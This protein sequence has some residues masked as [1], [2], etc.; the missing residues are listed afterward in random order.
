MRS[1]S[2]SGTLVRS[3]LAALG[4]L[5]L[6][7]CGGGGGD[8]GAI[9]PPATGTPP[10]TQ[11]PAPDPSYSI[12]ADEAS[13][14]R[15]LSVATFGGTRDEIAALVGRDAADWLADE[16][17]KPASP[18][19]E[20]VL[21][22][23]TFDT[24]Q[25][26]NARA[27]RPHHSDLFWEAMIGADDQLRQRMLFALSQIIVVSEVNLRQ[28]H[29]HATYMDALYENA[30]GNYRDVLYDVTYTPTMSDYLTYRGSRKADANTGRLPDENY[31]REILQLFSIGLVEL[32]P[33]GTPRLVGGESVETFDNDDIVNL[34][35]VFTGM[36]FDL[37]RDPEWLTWTVP[38]VHNANAHSPESKVF[39]GVNI[40]ENTDGATSV[41][42][43]IDGIFAHPNVAPF[44]SRQLIQRFTLSSPPPA[45]V[46][47]V[48]SAF[49]TGSYTADNGRAF[50][51]GVRGDLQAT[52]AAVLLDETLFGAATD[53]KLREPVL[54]FAHLVRALEMSNIDAAVENRLRDA[55]ATG[56]SLGQHPFRPPSVFNFY[57]PGYV[58]PNTESG[59][60]GMTA[61][62]LQIVNGATSVGYI[63]FVGDYIFD[64][65][66]SGGN[67]SFTPNYAPFDA[68]ADDPAGLVRFTDDLLTGGRLPTADFDEMVAVIDSMPL[69][70]ESLDADRRKRAQVAIYLIAASSAFAVVQ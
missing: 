7:A 5:T 29:R 35:R 69:R 53:G 20:Q 55:S 6:A 38:L 32:N 45:Y 27:D 14:Q 15:F 50:G 18:Y 57:R 54:R 40:P 39:L 1:R 22:F 43:A 28:V 21:P 70:S 49:E 17:A 31:A 24:D 41:T 25:T 66:P 64:R 60:A 42:R 47:R 59:A 8:D 56:V 67:E 12:I 16:F 46:A 19:T 11:P 65:T 58:A 34:S 2:R 37:S 63:N 3:L 30:F 4:M 10:P 61:P 9:V 48:A 52:L 26:F 23:V 36:Q 68:L 44:I 13:A 51:T 33:D 62:E